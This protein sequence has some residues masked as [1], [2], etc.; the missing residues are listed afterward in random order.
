M[1]DAS[2]AWDPLGR[3]LHAFLAGSRDEVLKVSVVGGEE[4]A[5][6]AA[7]FFRESSAFEPWEQV[8]L[9]RSHGRV[10]DLG[11]GAGCHALA[12]QAR[13]VTV[14]A[15]DVSE[16]A[17]QVMTRRGVLD[18]RHGTA[19]DVHDGPYDTVLLLMHGAGLGG[20]LA[21]L[22]ALLRECLR[23]LASG[24]V[25]LVDSADPRG[26][27]EPGEDDPD[28]DALP[29]EL[30]GDVGVAAMSLTWNGIT[31]DPFPWT[32]LS[33]RA[34]TELA[35]SADLACEVLWTGDEGH[36]VACLRPSP[37]G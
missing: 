3:A 10:L 4:E 18:A 2:R 30:R 31:G 12:L 6:P 16:G 22:S 36:Y 5:L 26:C 23:L 33:A 27:V 21:G 13:G 29:L 20:D 34:L 15:V 28:L 14:T 19:A 11:A 1:A 8:A 25:I 17:V 35:R 7:T 32:Y 9:A 24:G 37:E